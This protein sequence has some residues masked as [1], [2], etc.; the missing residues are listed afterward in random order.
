MPP[1]NAEMADLLR[2]LLDVQRE[3]VALLRAQQAA[4]DNLSRWRAFLHRWAKDFPDVGG[5]CKQI[6]PALERTYIT[7]LQEVTERV[8]EIGD[9]LEDEFV[10]TE[11]LDRY[12]TR[13][14]QL[15]NILGSVSPIADATPSG[16]PTA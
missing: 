13:V 9:D 5:G 15:G 7:V 8:R 6:L 4:N 12:A 2:Q 11:F 3:Q 14:T 1:S 16:P 10:L